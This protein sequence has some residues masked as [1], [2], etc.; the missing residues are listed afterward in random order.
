MV[1]QKADGAFEH[2]RGAIKHRDG[3]VVFKGSDFKVNLILHVDVEYLFL[4]IYL[5]HGDLV[6][7]H[8]S[9]HI[10]GVDVVKHVVPIRRHFENV[11]SKSD[12]D[13]ADE[14]V[15]E[16]NSGAH[17]DVQVNQGRL[18]QHEVALPMKFESA[19]GPAAEVRVSS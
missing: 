2:G 13:L 9:W 10:D 11:L 3:D 5:M 12:C 18:Q 1:P 14:A 17:L 4:F 16:T 7:S 6:V 8:L 19:A 15:V